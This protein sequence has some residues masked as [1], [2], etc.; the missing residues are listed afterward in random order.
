MRGDGCRGTARL[1]RVDGT[2]SASRAK[3]TTQSLPAIVPEAGREY[4]A[5]VIA[6]LPR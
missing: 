4:S 2:R 3:A 6:A 5:Y 1:L